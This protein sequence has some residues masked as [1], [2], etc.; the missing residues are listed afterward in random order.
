MRKSQRII[1]SLV[2]RFI[3]SHDLIQNYCFGVPS[4]YPSPWLGLNC[5]SFWLRKL[6]FSHLR[7][8]DQRYPVSSLAFLSISFVTFFFSLFSFS[9][10]YFLFSLFLFS[11]FFLLTPFSVFL[12]CL[13]YFHFCLALCCLF[14]F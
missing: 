5:Q 4:T 2:G 11:L 8:F 10:F 12:I 1:P 9:R 13:V 7:D 3:S 6:L 14:V